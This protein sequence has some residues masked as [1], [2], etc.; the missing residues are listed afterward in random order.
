MSR[1]PPS[2]TSVVPV[3]K[4]A[5]ADARKQIAAAMSSGLPLDP[6]T[7][8]TP[9]FTFGL[10]H[11]IGVSTAPG[12]TQLMRIFFDANSSLNPRVKASIPPFELA[13]GTT[14][15]V[16]SCACTELMLT[17]ELPAGMYGTPYLQNR[18]TERRLT[19]STLSQSSSVS[20]SIGLNVIMAASLTTTWIFPHLSTAVLIAACTSAEFETSAFA[21]ILSPPAS[22]IILTVSLPC[23]SFRSTT[24]TR[25]PSAARRSQ[26]AR[27]MPDPP[28][29]TTQT[30]SVKRII[31]LVLFVAS[32]AETDVET[33]GRKNLS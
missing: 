12:A 21:K 13:Y 8:S 16:V 4:R 6:W 9:L 22:L 28:P 17:M 1:R 33:L 19:A 15:F 23:S 26:V 5:S 3:M 30:L 20:S 18:K 14:F 7:F 24:T 2:T 11:S 25:A 31:P 32:I 27:P 10:D 29:L